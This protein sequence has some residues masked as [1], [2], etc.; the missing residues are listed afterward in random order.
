[1]KK[2]KKLLLCV[3]V[4]KEGNGSSSMSINNDITELQIDHNYINSFY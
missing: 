3:P 1:M 2:T 4:F